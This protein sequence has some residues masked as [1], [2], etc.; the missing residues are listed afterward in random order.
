MSKTLN[1]TV[2][3]DLITAIGY[4]TSILGV[5][6]S[7][8]DFDPIIRVVGGV[9]MLC[10]ALLTALLKW[11]Q[12]KQNREDYEIERLQFLLEKSLNE[13]EENLDPVTKKI[14]RELTEL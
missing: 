7:F 2:Q 4:I 3:P 13:N 9:I 12:Y 11:Q 5:G 8:T 10:I 1:M 14:L 6:I